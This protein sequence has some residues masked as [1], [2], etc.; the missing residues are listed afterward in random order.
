MPL[1]LIPLALWVNAVMLKSQPDIFSL[2]QLTPLEILSV[3]LCFVGLGIRILTVAYTPKN[4]SGRNTSQG[5]VADSINTSGCYSVVRHPL[6]V[7]NFFMWLGIAV[8][9]GNIWFVVSFVLVYWL[10]Y[11][12]IMYAEENF[13]INKF[14]DK[15][16]Q[17]ASK[18]PA[19]IPAIG[20]WKAPDMY[21]SW[22]KVLKK[23]KNGLFAIFLLIFLFNCW[24]NWLSNGEILTSKSWSIYTMIATGV[25]YFVLK[26]VKYNT[27]FLEEVDR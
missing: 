15:Y 25:L 7:G 10:Y 24:V 17:Y 5:Q 16:L 13:L 4:T 6:Y 12:R 20:Q 27:K 1:V 11:E 18:T 22:K 2:T 9:P 26:F 21:F 3:V 8:L 14:G 19:F 23:E